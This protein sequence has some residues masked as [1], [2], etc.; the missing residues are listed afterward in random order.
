LALQLGENVFKH[1]ETSEMNL[2]ELMSFLDA[3]I[4]VRIRDIWGHPGLVGTIDMHQ[5]TGM[6]HS[7]DEKSSKALGISLFKLISKEMLNA[8]KTG[9][10][11]MTPTPFH[12][13]TFRVPLSFLGML[14]AVSILH[15]YR[16][17][18]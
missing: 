11:M 2:K 16:L 4:T 6:V 5:K 8:F 9:V 10:R 12:F 15:K 17:A 1:V 14:A 7:V 13:M 18:F 3:S